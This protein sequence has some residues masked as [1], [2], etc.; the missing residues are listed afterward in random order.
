MFPYSSA[1]HICYG[2]QFCFREAKNT[3]AICRNILLPL[4]IFPC[5]RAKGAMLG[6]NVSATMSEKIGPPFEL[7]MPTCQTCGSIELL[8]LRFWSFLLFLKPV[9]IDPAKELS[10]VAPFIQACAVR[11]EDKRY[12]FCLSAYGSQ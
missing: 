12:G 10:R 11:N 7:R 2:S 4:R 3:S 1:R 8:G 9:K 5:F 6:N